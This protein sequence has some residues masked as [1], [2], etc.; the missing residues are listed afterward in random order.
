MNSLCAA[1]T[2]S[3]LEEQA[4]RLEIKIEDDFSQQAFCAECPAALGERCTVFMESDLVSYAQRGAPLE[5]R[6]VVPF[7]A[8]QGDRVYV[9]SSAGDILCLDA[10]GLADGND[11]PFLDE[12]QY[13]KNPPTKQTSAIRALKTTRR[14]AITGTPVENRLDELWSLFHFCNRGLLG[15]RTGFQKRFA[16]PI[17]VGDFPGFGRDQTIGSIAGALVAAVGLFL[18]IKAK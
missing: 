15:T 16:D 7:S 11:G 2:G 5:D 13:I 17:G 18:T 6:L 8:V 14:V 1:G 3:F 10:A 9:V 4:D 12:A